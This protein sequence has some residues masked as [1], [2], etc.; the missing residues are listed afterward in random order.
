MYDFVLVI[1]CYLSS[2]S[3]RFRDTTSQKSRKPPHRSLS[4]NPGGPPPS[5][6]AKLIVLKVNMILLHFDR[7]PQYSTF[8]NFVTT[9]CHNA[10]SSKTTDRRHIMIIAELCN[11]IYSLRCRG[12]IHSAL[13]WIPVSLKIKL[14][15]LYCRYCGQSRLRDSI[16]R[17]YYRS[18]HLYTPWLRKRTLDSMPEYRI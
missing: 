6:A 16:S 10:L 3:P 4:P 13:R 15:R 1:N 8:S 17:L 11:T 12:N 2:I 9:F 14:A 18:S 7:K 5:F